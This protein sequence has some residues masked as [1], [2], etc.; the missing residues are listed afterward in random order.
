M[1]AALFDLSVYHQGGG[2]GGFYCIVHQTT[3]ATDRLIEPEFYQKFAK[4]GVPVG[5]HHEMEMIGMK[6]TTSWNEWPEGVPYHVHTNPHT[7]RTF[8]C[9]PETISTVEQALAIFK[10]FCAGSM[11]S[12]KHKKDFG[13]LWKGDAEAF[14]NAM[15]NEYYIV[16]QVDMHLTHIDLKQVS[17]DLTTL[18]GQLSALPNDSFEV[19]TAQKH[20]ELAKI[21]KLVQAYLELP[22]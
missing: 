4:N 20:A 3:E 8:V 11:Y 19:L 2:R 13:H 10:V 12:Y 18:A 15:K 21:Y 22:T 17:K 9:W 7:K 6:A 16:V 5:I 1:K 14:L